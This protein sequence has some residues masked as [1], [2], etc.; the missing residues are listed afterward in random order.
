LKYIEDYEGL[1]KY[2][3]DYHLIPKS[4]KP[5]LLC[6]DGLDHY[7]ENKSF[8][9]LTRMMRLNFVMTLIRDC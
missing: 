3:A 4:K 9:N 6:I 5:C 2:L 7:I 1:V 8:N